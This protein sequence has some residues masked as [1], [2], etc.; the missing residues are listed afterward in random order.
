[1]NGLCSHKDL[2]TC[3]AM[4]LHFLGLRYCRRIPF[5]LTRYRYKTICRW[6]GKCKKYS[7]F[8]KKYEGEIK[9]ILGSLF[10]C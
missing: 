1:M 6:T 10:K 2:T 8:S 3:L 4:F 7:S 5:C 9:E